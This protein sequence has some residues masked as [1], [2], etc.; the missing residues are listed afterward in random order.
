MALPNT[1]R[2][3]LHYRVDRCSWDIHAGSCAEFE[4]AISAVQGTCRRYRRQRSH[5]ATC[6][7]HSVQCSHAN[8][9]ECERIR[10]AARLQ[11]RERV[12]VA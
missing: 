4:Q 6:P 12:P 10:I 2:T 9:A 3:C 7:Y 8:V 5:A 11:E 1:C